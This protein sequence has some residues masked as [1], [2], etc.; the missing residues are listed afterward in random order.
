LQI[1]AASVV[2]ATAV[3]LLG[4]LLYFNTRHGQIRIEIDDRDA[5]VLVD[6]NRSA[7]RGWA[8][9]SH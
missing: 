7:S 5:V 9:P 6:A 8:N 4:V 2:A 1:I 3:G